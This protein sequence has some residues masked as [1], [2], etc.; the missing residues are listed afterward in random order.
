MKLRTLQL[1]A[2]SAT[3]FSLNPALAAE[4][5]GTTANGA[6]VGTAALP[7]SRIASR[8]ESLAGSPQNAASLVAGL[9]SGSVINLDAAASS[10]GIS[11]TPATAQMGYGNVT[12]A[13]SLA[14]HQLAAQ[15]I[16]EP[17]PEQLRIALN[18]G[19]L[20]GTNGS[21]EMAGV[22]QLRSQGM[23]WGDI[24]HQIGVSP[25][26]RPLPAATG[27][28]GAAPSPPARMD[29]RGGGYRHGA[30]VSGDGSQVHGRAPGYGG[31]ASSSAQART[32]TPARFEAKA[33]GGGERASIA[34][35]TYS[36]GMGSHGRSQ[37]Q[38]RG[39]GHP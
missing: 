26:N 31:T 16:L 33:Q 8:F 38:V 7:A 14:Q 2:V 35:T 4:A 32:H 11:F 28:P 17:T 25:S 9:R 22:L 39:K 12:R 5:T 21:V 27:T 1:L 13:L 6:V 30:I 36:I 18:G 29:P 15:G 19:T 34:A 3:C 37:A 10:S 20:T 23:G 24:A